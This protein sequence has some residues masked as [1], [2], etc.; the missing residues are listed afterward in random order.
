MHAF[1]D[2]ASASRKLYP[3]RPVIRPLPGTCFILMIP[4]FKPHRCKNLV[5]SL[6]TGTVLQSE[7]PI[8]VF[9]KVESRVIP[10]LGRV[11]RPTPKIQ[12]PVEDMTN[13]GARLMVLDPA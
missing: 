3:S 10:D 6:T 11:I 1:N 9:Q 4:D 7:G 5:P 2:I 13:R 12:V 8:S